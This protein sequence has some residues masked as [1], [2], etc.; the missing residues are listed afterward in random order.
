MKKIA[1][2]VFVVLILSSVM[3]ELAEAT[4]QITIVNPGPFYSVRVNGQIRDLRTFEENGNLHLLFFKDQEF[5]GEEIFDKDN[6][7]IYDSYTENNGD[8]LAGYQNKYR[9]QWR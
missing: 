7:K 8:W 9:T 5:L 3:V 2:V 1:L 6:V 4:S